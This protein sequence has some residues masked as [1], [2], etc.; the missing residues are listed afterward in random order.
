MSISHFINIKNF[1]M[2]QYVFI[3]PDAFMVSVRYVGDSMFIKHI[4]EKIKTKLQNIFT[5]NC[6]L[7][8]L[9]QLFSLTLLISDLIHLKCAIAYLPVT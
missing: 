7:P 4:M 2:R 8:S 3:C 5:T 1:R 9:L 6:I